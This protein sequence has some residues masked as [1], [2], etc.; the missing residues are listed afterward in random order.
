[1]VEP[2]NLQPQISPSSSVL[3]TINREI[4]RDPHLVSEHTRRG[5]RA[6][7][8][9]FESWRAGRVMSKLLVEQYSA[10][11]QK[12]GKS[13]ST[14][15]RSLAAVRWWARRIA[16]LSFEESGLSKEAREEIQVQS[17]RVVAVSNVKGERLPKGRQITTGELGGLMLACQ[18]DHTPAG[19]RDTAMIAL[20]WATGARQNEITSLQLEDFTITSQEVGEGDLVILHGKGS[21]QRTAYIFNGAF[22]ALVDWL[23]VRGS[24]PGPLFCAIRKGGRVLASEG[25][26]AEAMRLIL[27]KRL[28]EARI[29]SP[30]TWHDF[31]RSFIS[32]LLDENIDLVTVQ[33]LAGHSSPTTTSAYDR[34]GEQ[35]KRKAV[36]SLFVPYEKRDLL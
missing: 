29:T 34:R 10:D 3:E 32:N 15:N 16:D 21:K 25:L 11:L 36:K 33:K 2:S 22:H 28:K 12:Q 6:D 30:A 24:E 23:Q 26:S 14:I 5:Y 1:M 35:V 8:E 13:P 19:A 17:N 18:A 31:R 27:D 7:L 4:E 9:R 20:A